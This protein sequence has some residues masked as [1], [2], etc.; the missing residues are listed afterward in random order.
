MVEISYCISLVRV[1]LK[2]VRLE[3]EYHCEP[4]LERGIEAGSEVNEYHFLRCYLVG[5]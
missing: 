1:A 5:C 4:S 3:G 2:T